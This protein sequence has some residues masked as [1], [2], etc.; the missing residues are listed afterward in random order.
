MKT[1]SAIREN[2]GREPL[3]TIFNPGIEKA[4]IAGGIAYSYVRE[5][6]RHIG[7]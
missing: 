1:W 3:V 6:T 5:D 7:I 4:I 2:E